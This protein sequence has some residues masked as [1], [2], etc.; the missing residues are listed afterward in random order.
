MTVMLIDP[1]GAADMVLGGATLVDI[2]EAGEHARERIAGARN[3]PLVALD[4]LDGSAPVI[5]HCKSG[6]RTRSNAARL[7][8]AAG[9]LAYLLD[10]GID[11][12]KAA[13]LPTERALRQ[14]LDIMRQVQIIGGSLVVL[15]AIL[16]WLFS[17]AFLILAGA[18]GAGMLHAGLTGSCAMARLLA[19]L[20]WNRAI[21][22]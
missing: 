18:V 7:A 2:R 12:W 21:R 17:P 19:P 13:G 8:L 10:G 11:G 1:R 16:A 6:Q 3:V 9:G 20:P 22:Q 14:P 4:R 5:F 15:S